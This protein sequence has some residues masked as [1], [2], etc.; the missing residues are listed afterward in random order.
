MD[1]L[2]VYAADASVQFICGKRA[3]VCGYMHCSILSH[4]KI[5]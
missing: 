3:G 1:V 2:I 5:V 4:K